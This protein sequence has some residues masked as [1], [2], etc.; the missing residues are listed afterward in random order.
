MSVNPVVEVEALRF[1]Y[2]GQRSHALALERFELAQGEHVLLEGASGSGKSTLLSLLAGVLLAS[3][4]SVRL[5]GE[6]WRG[7][8]PAARDRRRAEHIGYVFQQFNLLG[9]MSAVDNV[10]L[11]CAF[12]NPRFER[13]TEAGGSLEHAARE[14]LDRMQ[15]P[16]SRWLAK[17][18]ALSVGEQ[19]RVAA[20]RALIGRPSLILADEP[21]SA[22]DETLRDTFIEALLDAATAAGCSL[23][24]V[25]HDRAL[26][27]RFARCERL[28]DRSAQGAG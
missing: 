26:A 28:N 7:I 6:D 15:L 23:L 20:A 9:W 11:G 8:A 24:V 25:S 19:Q 4:G 18:A 14:A 16:A 22:M 5:L 12:S 13:A 10:V 1:H 27:E 17:G 2:P 21:T 3:S